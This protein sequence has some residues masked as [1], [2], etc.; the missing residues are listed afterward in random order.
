MRYTTICVATLEEMDKRVNAMIA[1][2]WTPLGGIAVVSNVID[3][4][5]IQALIRN[6]SPS[7]PLNKLP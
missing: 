1:D 3:Y 4:K 5:F 7:P 6:E 2:G